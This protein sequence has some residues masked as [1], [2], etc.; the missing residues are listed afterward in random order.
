MFEAKFRNLE[1][2][3]Y[4]NE[5][6][7]DIEGFL[8]LLRVFQTN[9]KAR[10]LDIDSISAILKTSQH[11]MLCCDEKFEISEVPRYLIN[12]DLTLALRAIVLNC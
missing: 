12:P 10:K 2:S 1:I 4:L 11:Q 5:H 8:Q 6:D 9:L 7:I 3:G